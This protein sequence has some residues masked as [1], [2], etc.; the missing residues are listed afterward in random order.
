MGQGIQRGSPERVASSSVLQ[1]G[2]SGGKVGAGSVTSN[3]ES[4]AGGRDL[5]A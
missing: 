2:G 5:G 3:G 1:G 4:R